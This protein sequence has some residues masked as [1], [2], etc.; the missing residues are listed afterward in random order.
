M[1]SLKIE[2]PAKPLQKG[3]G[4]TVKLTAQCD[5]TALAG[6]NLLLS[7]D[8][9]VLTLRRLKPLISGTVTAEKSSYPTG[10]VPISIVC[11]PAAGPGSILVA[12]L[13]F[14]AADRGGASTSVQVTALCL[15]HVD[16]T[17]EAGISAAELVTIERDQ[18]TI[19]VSPANYFK[20]PLPAGSTDRFYYTRLKAIGGAP[21]LIWSSTEMPA[22]LS[23]S[24]DGIVSG[25]PEAE[26]ELI[27]EAS[28]SDSGAPVQQDGT[29]FAIQMAAGPLTVPPIVL[30][31]FVVGM[32]YATQ[33]QARGGTPPYRWTLLSG[34]LPAGIQLDLSGALRG[35]CLS[36]ADSVVR[37]L[38]VDAQHRQAEASVSMRARALFG[39]ST[40]GSVPGARALLPLPNLIP[41]P[42]EVEIVVHSTVGIYPGPVRSGLTVDGDDV[43]TGD[44]SV[45]THTC[46]IGVRLGGPRRVQLHVDEEDTAVGAIVQKLTLKPAAGHSRPGAKPVA[47][48]FEV[49][50]PAHNSIA[51]WGRTV[52]AGE[53]LQVAAVLPGSAD[54]LLVA[55]DNGLELIPLESGAAHSAFAASTFSAM[56]W[57]T[58]GS[59]RGHELFGAGGDA[60]ETLRQE[61]DGSWSA[62]V[63]VSGESC[64]GLAATDL[65][66]DGVVEPVLGTAAEVRIYQSGGG[67]KTGYPTQGAV[68]R[69]VVAVATGNLSG[70]DHTD[71]VAVNRYAETVVAFLRPAPNLPAAAVTAAASGQPAAVVVGNVHGNGYPGVAVACRSDN[72]VRTY[73]MEATGTLAEGAVFPAGAGPEDMLLVRLS[74]EGR[75][76]IVT[77]DAG[78]DTVTVLY[79]A[80]AV[81][82]GP[83]QHGSKPG[84]GDKIAG[85]NDLTKPPWLDKLDPS[86]L[87]RSRVFCDPDRYK[88]PTGAGRIAALRG[89]DGRVRLM[90]LGMAEGELMSWTTH[91]FL[92][93]CQVAPIRIEASGV[94]V[95]KSWSSPK[96][97]LVGNAGGDDLQVT[98]VHIKG[99]DASRFRL[100]GP[101]ALPKKVPPGKAVELKVGFTGGGTG[102]YLCSVQIATD[103]PL[104]PVIT[105]YVKVAVS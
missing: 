7:F 99:K 92:P 61:P 11:S 100:E 9:T 53:P 25:W 44:L 31:D 76:S 15:E 38:V 74:D 96:G 17:R 28:V 40:R 70:P 87:K 1:S 97:F 20:V 68:G 98:S 33:L 95:N 8:P 16:L 29:A 60:V 21:P 26:G 39:A 62:T 4:Y 81:S 36:T 83:A 64:T 22:G 6:A 77:A 67:G 94:A 103:D 57:T 5:G 18:L 93:A 71:L 90:A 56:A 34:R 66:G 89:A 102:Q 84:L 46:P 49:I 75:P 73:A 82:K 41:Q 24:P 27:F 91:T 51:E 78:S 10:L 32:Y 104:Y 3:G 2:V 30:D 14:L 37:F 58:P 50:D 45:G 52:R 43:W 23:L 47:F 80:P 101:P 48:S 35:K 86:L 105:A 72:V 12:T 85:W 88:G 13:E 54:E 19:D 55:R 59:A 65:D 63:T 69:E 79:P 42:F